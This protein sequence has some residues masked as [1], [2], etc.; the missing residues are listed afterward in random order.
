MTD[1]VAARRLKSASMGVVPPPK[2]RSAT[3]S[4]RNSLVA[5]RLLSRRLLDAVFNQRAVFSTTHHRKAH[6]TA[7]VIA[8]G[9]HLNAL[10]PLGENWL[11]NLAADISE[12]HVSAAVRVRELSMLQPEKVQDSRIEIIDGLDVLGGDI[13]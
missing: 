1:R 11:N 10:S 6:Q 13:A 12:A 5:E 8:V 3:T 4:S 9:F 7:T 2:S